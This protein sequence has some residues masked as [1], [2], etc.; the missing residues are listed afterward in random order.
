VYLILDKVSGN[1]EKGIGVNE[2]R[3]FLV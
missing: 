1:N 3:Q 2:N